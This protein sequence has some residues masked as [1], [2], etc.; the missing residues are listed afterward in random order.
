[1]YKRQSGCRVVSK[2]EKVE[3][4][5]TTHG[6]YRRVRPALSI[7]A[8]VAGRSVM[9]PVMGALALK[10][11][12]SAYCTMIEGM[13]MVGSAPPIEPQVPALEFAITTPTAPAFCAFFTFTAKPQ[14]PRSMM[15]ILPATAAVLV[16]AEQPSVVDGPAP[17]AA[18]SYTHL[19]VYKRQHQPHAVGIVAVPMFAFADQGIDRAGPQRARAAG[20]AQRKRCV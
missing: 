19:D 7:P 13:V 18:V 2:C 16:M 15:A 4:V 17:S 11:A 6:E 20:S 12:P 14:V 3:P 1:M 9:P 5:A 10:F 8:L